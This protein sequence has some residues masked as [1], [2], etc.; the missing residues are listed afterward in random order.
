MTYDLFTIFPGAGGITVVA[1]FATSYAEA[2][3][4][5]HSLASLTMPSLAWAFYIYA[6]G[7]GLILIASFML[8]FASPDN[9]LA[10][11]VGYF[12]LDL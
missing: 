8:C 3:S 12:V 11:M 9:M 2:D 7:S 10:Q 4:W 1:L 5:Q 6:A